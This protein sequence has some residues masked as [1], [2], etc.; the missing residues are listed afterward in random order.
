MGNWYHYVPRLNQKHLLLKVFDS[1][2]VNEIHQMSGC[3][4]RTFSTT[5][6]DRI[7]VEPITFKG[8]I[9]QSSVKDFVSYFY[10]FTN[11]FLTEQINTVYKKTGDVKQ[12]NKK[13][14]VDL[15][16]DLYK[17]LNQKATFIFILN[18]S[19]SNTYFIE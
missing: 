15:Y 7:L 1:T 18:C 11:T 8:F 6:K 5:S 14:Y 13:F 12:I 10:M 17:D 16:C 4:N 2:I 19:I 3:E 9:W